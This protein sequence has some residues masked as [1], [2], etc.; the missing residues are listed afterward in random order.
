MIA[1]FPENQRTKDKVTSF[2]DIDAINYL[3][4]RYYDPS[5]ARFTEL[6]SYSG[7]IHSPQSLHKYLYCNA[8][9]IMLI[10]PRGREGDLGSTLG[11]IGL[12]MNL[13]AMS[14]DASNLLVA[15]MTHRTEDILWYGT[16][17]TL[18]VAFLF[19]PGSGGGRMGLSFAMS[20]SGEVS[21]Q[22]S[23]AFI[24]TAQYYG[25]LRILY[26]GFNGIAQMARYE[27]NSE[28]SWES[29]PASS[30][31]SSP[32]SEG[33]KKQLRQKACD[34]FEKI[35]GFRA[36]SRNMEVHHRIP[37]EWSHLFPDMMPNH[38]ANLVGVDKSIHQP[39]INSIWTTFRN[40]PEIRYMSM[41][42]LREAVLSQAEAIDNQ[43]GKNFIYL[44]E[45]V[46]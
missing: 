46:K 43:F 1:I 6:D 2:V 25:P 42:E 21:L 17:L 29:S 40:N 14:W 3:K 41:P 28:N 4:P 23:K 30:Q 15:A 27:A 22:V 37:L 5:V 32:L 11:A 39:L 16:F 38:P 10:D 33:A 8:D 20:A 13:Q 36:S 12:A 7:D 31:Q 34:I 45:T 9:P 26:G 44:D 19:L 35:M 18:D 24:E